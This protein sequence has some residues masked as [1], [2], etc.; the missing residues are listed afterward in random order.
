MPDSRKALGDLF[1]K[2]GILAAAVALLLSLSSCALLLASPLDPLTN[3]TREDV[4]IPVPDDPISPSGTGS[5]ESTTSDPQSSGEKSTEEDTTADEISPEDTTPSEESSSDEPACSH[6]P[7]TLPAMSPTCT[8]EGSTEGSVCSL[9]NTVLV[10]P[11]TLPPTGHTYVD[12][13]CSSCGIAPVCPTPLT[14]TREITASYGRPVALTWCI[15]EE[16]L[17]PV[18]YRITVQESGSETV[19]REM[20]AREASVS[21]TLPGE[22]VLYTVRVYAL[23]RDG[24]EEGRE[25]AATQSEPLELTV[26]VPL[27]PMLESPGFITGNMSTAYPDKSFTVS[28]SP[29]P[30]EGGEIRYTAVLTSPD[31]V[32]VSVLEGSTATTCV[33]EETLLFSEGIYRLTVYASD[34]TAGYRDSEGAVLEISVKAPPEDDL[35]AYTTPERYHSDYFYRYLGTCPNGDALQRFYTMVDAALLDFHSSNATAQSV[36]LSDGTLRYYAAKLDYKACGLT[37]G[38]A[39]SVRTLYMYDHPLYYWVS[40]VYVYNSTSLYVCVEETYIHGSARTAANTVIYDAVRE[41]AAPLVGE[42]SAYRISLAYYELLLERADYAFEEDGTTPRDDPWAH[43]IV[44]LLDGQYKAVVCEGFAETYSLLLNFH[45][46]ENVMVSG[47]SR[48]VGHLWNL[49]RMGDGAWYW[50]DITWDDK[51]YSPLGTDYKYFCVTDTQDVLYYFYRD[52]QSSGYHVG[53]D[54]VSVFT[55]DHSIRWDHSVELDM[56]G[57][58]PDRSPVPYDGEELTLRETFTVDGMTYALTGYGKVQLIDAGSRFSVTVPETVTHNG[59]TYAVTS[60]GLM[61]RNGVF[62]TGRV[63]SLFTS[64]VYVSK[65]VSHIWDGALSG[66]IVNV[67]VD[68]E[69]PCYTSENGVLMRK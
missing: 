39:A 32:S 48:G 68:P 6:V 63:I 28:W 33:L 8:E 21:L 1:R 20:L 43:S 51:T 66:I 24:D 50:C 2:T 59:I 47:V 23:Y 9:C 4:S 40:N 15:P 22:D 13:Q 41:M 67:T 5:A 55:E 16:T 38:E 31:G 57:A 65:N 25:V 64:S 26:A 42:T 10:A 61:D 30:A 3:S 44:G 37:L 18:T 7:A 69:N 45:G 14:D 19:I 27:R 60:I 54:K 34:L 35:Q 56:S 62:V 52:G 17:Y 29:V 49:I 36:S 46:V 11:E 12:L 53:D 58:I